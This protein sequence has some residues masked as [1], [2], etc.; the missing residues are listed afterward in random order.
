MG[1]IFRFFNGRATFFAIAILTIGSVL[2]FKDKLTAQFVSLGVMLQG[3]I[4]THSIAQD[5]A[6]GG[7]NSE[8][9]KSNNVR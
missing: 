7:A 4:V 6:P 8:S 1:R 9:V 2:A 5:R 3:F